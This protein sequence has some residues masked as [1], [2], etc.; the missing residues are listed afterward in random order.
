MWNSDIHWTLLRDSIRIFFKS[1]DRKFNHKFSSR[2]SGY[3]FFDLKAKLLT[4][5]TDSITNA[6]VNRGSFEIQYLYDSL[7]CEPIPK[8]SPPVPQCPVFGEV[9]P[10]E[11]YVPTSFIS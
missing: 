11:G 7:N 4:V 6:K 5:K 1:R 10:N 2:P 9:G 3:Y 8:G